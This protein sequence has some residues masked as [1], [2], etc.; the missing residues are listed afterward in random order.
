MVGKKP[1]RFPSTTS[2]FSR[3]RGTGFITT[4]YIFFFP[5]LERR[6]TSSQNEIVILGIDRGTAA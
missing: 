3:A 5:F 2:P 4:F 6:K 1:L